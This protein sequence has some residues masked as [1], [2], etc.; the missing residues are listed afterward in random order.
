LLAQGLVFLGIFRRT[1]SKEQLRCGDDE[2]KL[3]EG[4]DSS[5][6]T[7]ADVIWNLARS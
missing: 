6:T 2:E 5:K 3:E 1:C 4:R 7:T